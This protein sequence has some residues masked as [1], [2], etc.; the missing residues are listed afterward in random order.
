MADIHSSPED[1]TTSLP[2]LD[3]RYESKFK[4]YNLSN[5]THVVAHLSDRKIKNNMD[6]NADISNEYDTENYLNIIGNMLS[7]TFFGN[8][9][10]L[11]W[12][13]TEQIGRRKFV[14]FTNIEKKEKRIQ[15]PSL[16]PRNGKLQVVE[17]IFMR[18]SP[19]EIQKVFWRPARPIVLRRVLARVKNSLELARVRVMRRR[20]DVNHRKVTPRPRKGSASA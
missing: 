2:A 5:I 9:N 6:S 12:L 20:L 14:A 1:I 7:V 11:D 17:V 18:T 15:S 3:V 10:Q 8:E 16:S 4:D 19:R 13:H